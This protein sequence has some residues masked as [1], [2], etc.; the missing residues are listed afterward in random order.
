MNFIWVMFKNSLAS[1]KYKLG[2]HLEYNW[3]IL[4]RKIIDVN[5]ENQKHINT[6]TM[7]GQNADLFIT[8]ADDTYG[9][10]CVLMG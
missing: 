4:F 9:C 1:Q 6:Y 8:K 10:Q 5:P 7:G 2:L 3:L